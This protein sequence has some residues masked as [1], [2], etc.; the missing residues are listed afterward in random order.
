[1]HLVKM[2]KTL[3][4]VSKMT[5]NFCRGVPTCEGQP[6]LLYI[7]IY[8]YIYIDAEDARARVEDDGE[9]L[10]RRPHLPGL[11]VCIYIDR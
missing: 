9:L 4:P 10:A 8:I 11:C 5:V 2:P 6:G 1:M 3:E 7:F